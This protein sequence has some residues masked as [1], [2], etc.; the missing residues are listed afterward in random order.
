ME[1]PPA[2]HGFAFFGP[3]AGV[4]AGGFCASAFLLVRKGRDVLVGQMAEPHE[5]WEE[6]WAPNLAIYSEAMLK[7]AFAGLRFPASYLRVGED[8]RDCA[9]RVWR[10]QLAFPGA[11][12]LAGPRILSEAGPS[13]RYPGE[14]HWDVVFLYEADAPAHEPPSPPPHWARLEWRS[15]ASLR[16]EDFVMTHGELLPLVKE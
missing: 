16:A 14:S 10:D 4:P 1:A 3:H 7:G 6:Q 13:R 15:P 9:L 11:P 12:Q 2:K 8:P 5:T